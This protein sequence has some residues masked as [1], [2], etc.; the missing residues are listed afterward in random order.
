MKAYIFG[1]GA[2]VGAGYPLASCLLLAL[3]DWL[4][5]AAAGDDPPWWVEPFQNRML[6]LRE[7]FEPLGTLEDVLEKLQ[8]YGTERIVPSGPMTYRQDPKDIGHDMSDYMMGRFRGNIEDKQCGFYP[9]YMRADLVSAFREM[10]YVIEENRVGEN[11]YDKLASAVD[12]GSAFITFNYDVALE[13][14]LAKAQKWDVST[15]YGFSAFADRQASTSTVY[16]LHGS[17]N[18]FKHPLHDVLPPY[19]FPRDLT[20]L[21]HVGLRDVRI[22]GTMPV[23]NSGTFILPNPTKEFY[24]EGLWLPLW[25]S[26]GNQLRSAD[27]IFIHGYSMPVS[28]ARG[29]Q[30]IFDNVQKSVDINI[31]SMNDSRRI[32]DDFV[33]EGFKNVRAFSNVGFESWADSL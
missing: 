21:G 13:R 3:S 26:A 28:D 23:D 14:A 32:A 33:R 6:Q 29:R 10:F 30:L 2:S 11:A 31:Y 15:G 12:A 24:W 25:R 7:T 18:W 4:D 19:F 27:E 8:K 22:N 20:I 9:Q 16:K 17:A 5:S 1:A